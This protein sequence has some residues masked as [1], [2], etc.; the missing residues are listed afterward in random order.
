[1]N[2]PNNELTDLTEQEEN[3]FVTLTRLTEEYK[4]M[5]FVDVSKFKTLNKELN[6]VFKDIQDTIPQNIIFKK[7]RDIIKQAQA[8]MRKID[9]DIKNYSKY[10]G[11]GLTENI[12]DIK[13]AFD[14]AEVATQTPYMAALYPEVYPILS[15]TLIMAAIME[16]LALV[17]KDVKMPLMFNR[18]MRGG[19]QGPDTPEIQG[20]LN[21]ADFVDEKELRRAAGEKFREM[22]KELESGVYTYVPYGGDPNQPVTINLKEIL[23]HHANKEALA[24]IIDTVPFEQLFGNKE[25]EEILKN[26]DPYKSY[27]IDQTIPH[28]IALEKILAAMVA[29]W[30]KEKA[31][32]KIIDTVPFEQLFGD[33]ELEEILKNYDPYKSYGI[34][35]TIPHDFSRPDQSP[36]EHLP[37]EMHDTPT[38]PDPLSATFESMSSA[39]SLTSFISGLCNFT[40][41][42]IASV[43]PNSNTRFLSP[44]ELPWYASC[45]EMPNFLTLGT[46]APLSQALPAAQGSQNSL[47]AA[48]PADT[49]P[50]TGNSGPAG[51][52]STKDMTMQRIFR[53]LRTLGSSFNYAIQG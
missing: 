18:G 6:S 41:Q 8:T 43:V 22:C 31:L 51:N 13:D 14:A 35:Q 1:M 48:S 36:L 29:H 45:E 38:T 33:K 32:A 7:Y 39:T 12:A 25:I 42:V 2:D 50:P 11:I 17:A 4:S 40:R 49:L 47:N 34:D 21:L 15:T 16:G 9:I 24:K 37:P 5:K 52:S 44:Q 46:L 53:E 26:Y 27:G 20:K 30:A 19:G 10:S 23:D 3:K 28:A